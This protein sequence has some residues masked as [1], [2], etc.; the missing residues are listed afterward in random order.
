MRQS[1]ETILLQLKE[2]LQTAI[3][4]EHST[5]PAYLYCYWTIK[6]RSSTVATT[7]FSIVK[8]EM[9]HMAMAANILNS[10]GGK[11]RLKGK[12]FIPKYPTP[13]PG[14][15][16]TNDPFLVD[17]DKCSIGAIST[18]MHI[19][20]PRDFSHLTSPHEGWETIGEFYVSIIHLINKL[21][22]VDFQHGMQ[23]R[24]KDAPKVPGELF[25]V[26]S[27]DDAL[28]AVNEIIEQGEGLGFGSAKLN[29]LNE[30]SHF[31]RFTEIYKEMGG[32]AEIDHNNF[33]S[34][35]LASSFRKKRYKKFQKGIINVIKSPRVNN[36]DRPEVFIANQKFNATYSKILDKLHYQFRSKQPNLEYGVNSMFALARDARAL[37][38]IP[39]DPNDESKGFC[40]PTFEYLYNYERVLKYHSG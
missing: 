39:V 10:I 21:E 11:P 15:D 38:S 30:E 18:F 36:P 26:F 27:R 17:L 19:E 32:S 37:M 9:L 40:G 28:K 5:I 8:E 13:L 29:Q 1:K 3:E 12:R 23:A 20:L 33:D 22:D 6:D 4:L 35:E 31:Y 34:N 14:H 24:Q 25:S 7:I 2:K 16:Q